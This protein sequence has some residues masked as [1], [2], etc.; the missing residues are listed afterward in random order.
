MK[1]K[2]SELKKIIQEKKTKILK[3]YGQEVETGSPL[4]EFARAYMGLGGAVTEQVDA[5]VGAYINGGGPGSEDFLETV[6]NQN[7]NAIDMAMERLGR[8]LRYDDLGD[9]GGM[10]LE[11]LERAQAIYRQGDDEDDEVEVGEHAAG[12][13]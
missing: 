6:Y 3:E 1:I 7:P 11:A 4:I 12:E 2:L 13:A 5:V 9:D 8:V 10:I